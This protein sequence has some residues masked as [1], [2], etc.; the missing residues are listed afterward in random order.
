MDKSFQNTFTGTLQQEAG[1]GHCPETYTNLVSA[2]SGA[3][4]TLWR[5]PSLIFMNFVRLGDFA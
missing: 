1:V 4:L 5:V 3:R 2:V